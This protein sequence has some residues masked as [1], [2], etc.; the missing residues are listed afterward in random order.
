MKSKIIKVVSAVVIVCLVG[1]GGYYFYNKSAKAKAAAKNTNRYYTVAAEK[2]N[3]DVTVSATGT[4]EAAQTKD[5]VANN[6]GTIQ[7]LSVNVGDTVSQGGTIAKVQSDDIDSAVSKANLTVQQQ[8]LQVNNAKN[9][10][11]QAMQQLSLQS[12]QND[13][14][15]KI[16]QQNK[17]TLTAPIGGV[18]VAK[19]DNNGDSV[20][21]G[22]ALITIADLSSMKVDVQVDE[23]DISKVKTGQTADLTFDAISGKTYTGTVD[24]ISQ[25]G[26]TSN[27]VTTYDV[28]VTVNNPD[29]V[30]LGMNA[31]VNIKV[32]SK[33]D[34]LTIPVEALV[35]RNNKKYVMV[36]TSGSDTASSK[37][38]W[39]QNS[40]SGNSQ[41]NSGSGSYRRNGENG[42]F[43]G[44]NSGR[45]ST[46]GGKLVEVQTGLENETTVEI[47]SGIKE[48]D[49]VMIQLPQV[50]STSSQKSGGFGG[51]GGGS[52]GGLGGGNRQGGSSNNSSSGSGNNAGTSNSSSNNASSGSNAAGNSGSGK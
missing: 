50:S 7:N 1:G 33:A 31:N 5:V 52:F 2:S 19:N 24:S 23:L 12:A 48:G 41:G 51:L 28:I 34:A 39:S 15:N 11:D 8:Q 4:V 35:E 16:E 43:G 14:N 21:A 30:K 29:G 37:G 25:M 22:K 45:T 6:S 32:S 27:N 47:T 9:A 46:L 36:K 10:D 17:M 49:E 3:I 40:S 18:V 44:N 42:A 20:Q 38:S 26:T 13:L